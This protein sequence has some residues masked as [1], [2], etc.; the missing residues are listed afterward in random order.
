MMHHSTT[1]PSR[2]LLTTA[3]WPSVPWMHLASDDRKL[4]LEACEHHQ[5]G[6]FR[7]RCLIA[8][9]NGV[10]QLT[11]PLLKG[12]HQQTPIRDVRIA[13]S[14]PWQRLHWRSI[15]TAYGNA[16]YFAHYAPELSV[17]F[18]KKYTFLFDLNEEALAW[19]FAKLGVQ[20]PIYHTDRY[21]NPASSGFFDVRRAVEPDQIAFQ[22]PRYGQV[23]EDRYGF[24]PRLSVLDALLCAGKYAAEIIENTVIVP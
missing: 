1:P 23:F 3:Y 7:N 22:V 14:E 9:P 13:Y 11:V 6:S 18:Q 2:V 24:I 5:K 12:K 8:G 10:Q 16:P 21:E 15:Q 17:F 20:K 19:L 4:Y